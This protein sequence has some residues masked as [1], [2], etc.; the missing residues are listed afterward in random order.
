M[1]SKDLNIGWLGYHIEGKLAIDEV[2]QRGNKISAILTLD[3]QSKSRRSAV[4][5]F[6]EVSKKYDIPL[7]EISNINSK[8]AIDL[9]LSLNLDILLVIGWS[10]ILSPS[11]LDCFKIG[12]IGAHASLLPDNR[13]SA[14][15]NWALI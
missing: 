2:L 12:A 3:Q 5:D 13:G 1:F 10:Q 9:L 15:I 11:V 8:E 4:A 14:P 6:L 7:F